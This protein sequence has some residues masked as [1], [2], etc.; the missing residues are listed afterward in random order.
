V[1]IYANSG[2]ILGMYGAKPPL[3]H[4]SEY[5]DRVYVNADTTLPSTRK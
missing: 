3:Q 1:D 2:P 5:R 4:T